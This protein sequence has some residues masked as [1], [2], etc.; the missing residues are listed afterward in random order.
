[1]GAK[2]V[3]KL[4]PEL[5]VVGEAKLI[6]E[7]KLMPALCVMGEA[8]LVGEA[9]LAPRVV[10]GPDLSSENALEAAPADGLTEY[11]TWLMGAPAD[12]ID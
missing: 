12:V 4:M 10:L 2:L 5:C 7:E 3:G 11:C 1:V 8:K 6:G 9:K